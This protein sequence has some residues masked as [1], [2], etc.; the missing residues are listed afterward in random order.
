MLIWLTDT[1]DTVTVALALW[2]LG[3]GL[4]IALLAA[5]AHSI[6]WQLANPNTVAPDRNTARTESPASAD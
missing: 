5:L 3:A 2:A 1:S 6:N 4:S